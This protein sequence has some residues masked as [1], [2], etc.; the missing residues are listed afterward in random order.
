MIAPTTRA[1]VLFAAGVPLAGF[2]ALA[3]A[4]LWPA[5]AVYFAATAAL[6]AA[7]VFLLLPRKKL[8]LARVAPKQIALGDEARLRLDLTTRGHTRAVTVDVRVELGSLAAAAHDARVVVGGGRAAV[9]EVPLRP[10]RRGLLKIAACFFR[11]AGPLGLASRVE[12]RALDEEIPVVP[13]LEAARLEAARFFEQR[14]LASGLKT[15]SYVGEGSEF[16]ALREFVPGL[17]SRALDWKSSAKHHK[18]LV[19]EFRAE[20]NHQ[21]VIAVDTGRLMSEPIAGKPRLDH[22]I[23]A[24]LLLS[25]IG[26]KAG[27]RVGWFAFDR[28]VRAYL[29][30]ARGMASLALMRATTARLEYQT[31]ETNFTLGLVEL[32]TRLRRRTLV[33]LLTDF[34]DTVSAELLVRSVGEVAKKH[35]VCF[36][37]LRDPLL[38]ELADGELRDEDALHRAVI[39]RDLLRERESVLTAL[40][41][42]GVHVVDASVNDAPAKLVNRYLD[43]RRKE[44]V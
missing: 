44:L 8:V 35:L 15:Q 24:G 3:R 23:H 12:R 37:A 4:E 42:L 26:L 33:V 2:V 17:D 38:S 32:L 14:T 28:A 5:W 18:L 13:N 21:V 34:V 43:I 40:L 6:F 7:D 20:R 39:A 9:V 10:L 27:D 22:A 30:P 29:P 41:R 25:T 19:R 36:V 31:A 1:V 11:Y 16:D